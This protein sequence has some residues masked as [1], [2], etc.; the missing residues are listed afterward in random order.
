MLACQQFLHCT[1]VALDCRRCDAKLC[2]A[3]GDARVCRPACSASAFSRERHLAGRQAVPRR[4]TNSAASSALASCGRCASQA[5]SAVRE[6]RPTGTL[7]RLLPL[8][9]TC[10]WRRGHRS[11]RRHRARRADRAPT[12]SPTRRPAA[13]EQLDDRVVA[14]DERRVS[15]LRHMSASATAWS[16]DSALGSGRA[17]FGVRTPVDAGWTPP[18]AAHPTAVQ[19]APGGQHDRQACAA[20]GPRCVQLRDPAP[21]MVRLHRQQIDTCSGSDRGQTLQRLAVH[22]Q[23]A[24]PPA[25]ARPRGAAGSAAARA[26]AAR[27]QRRPRRLR[28]GNSRDSP[29]LAISPM[30]TR[31]SVPMSAL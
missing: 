9:S 2:A 27:Q 7:R 11:S 29:A 23:R 10:A 20:R 24:R 8:P 30:R 26:A 25:A 3:S 14:R 12:S 5:S 28:L 31:K 1:Q 6:A 18:R 4:L 13:I 16:T 21:H 22:H 19:T 15:V 17:A